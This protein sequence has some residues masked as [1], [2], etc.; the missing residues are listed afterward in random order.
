M[1]FI[2]IF[3]KALI[4]HLLVLLFIQKLLIMDNKMQNS[5]RKTEITQ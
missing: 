1:A 3:L 5:K 2:L 4:L